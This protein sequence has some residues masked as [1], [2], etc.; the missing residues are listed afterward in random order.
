MGHHTK[1]FFN[2]DNFRWD[3]KKERTST[4]RAQEKLSR[5]EALTMSHWWQTPYLQ[6]G[7]PT[8]GGLEM[9]RDK[10]VGLR[11]EQKM[12]GRSR[13]ILM[14]VW[15]IVLYFTK[16]N[17]AAVK[18]KDL[19]GTGTAE[20]YEMIPGRLQMLNKGHTDKT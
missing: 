7:S 6:V 10:A 19:K 5:Q 2:Y 14:S 20:R 12:A 16:L 9:L 3:F 13:M 8:Q 15:V 11:L 17:Q 4:G 18:C 1:H